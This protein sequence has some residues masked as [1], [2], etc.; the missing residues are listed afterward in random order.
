MVE[1]LD[2]RISEMQLR[3]QWSKTLT[4]VSVRCNTLAMVEDLDN[5]ISEM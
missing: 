1:D 5:R 2:N 3:W 4:I